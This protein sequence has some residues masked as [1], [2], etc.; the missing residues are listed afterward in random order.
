MSKVLNDVSLCFKDLSEQCLSHKEYSITLCLRG[1]LTA[2]ERS[3]HYCIPLDGYTV[4]ER[5]PIAAAL[6]PQDHITVLHYRS[7]DGLGHVV[8]GVKNKAHGYQGVI[9][10][11]GSTSIYHIVQAS[12]KPWTVNPLFI[13]IPASYKLD[14]PSL[15]VD[16]VSNQ[17]LEYVFSEVGSKGVDGFFR[18]QSLVQAETFLNFLQVK[19]CQNLKEVLVQSRGN[20]KDLIRRNQAPVFDTYMLSMDNAQVE[21]NSEMHEGHV[22]RMS[23]NQNVWVPANAATHQA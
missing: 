5:S 12:S 13:Q 10:Q 1:L 3:K 15:S 16:P 2:I 19:S 18:H 4:N 17:Y 6:Q 22:Y 23:K 7:R 14:N 20:N 21:T 8:V 11:E 9:G